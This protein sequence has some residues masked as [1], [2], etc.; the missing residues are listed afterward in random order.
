MVSVSP[1]LTEL[2]EHKTVSWLL[3]SGFDDIAIWHTIW[4]HKKH[5]VCRVYHTERSVAYQDHAGRWY[6]GT[7]EQAQSQL[8]VLTRV[9]TTMEV[10][11]S[12]Q[13]HAKQ[14]PV[15]VE[16]AVCP[17]HLTYWSRVR[18]PGELGQW[19]QKVVWLVQVGV[20]G[21]TQEPWLVLTDWPIEDATSALRIFSM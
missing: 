21:T 16:I 17:L 4:D 5:L 14:Q 3:D 12:K 20:V 15:E 1:A 9:E 6:W 11:G 19:V 2:K 8:R 7:L 13:A 18:R 10:Q